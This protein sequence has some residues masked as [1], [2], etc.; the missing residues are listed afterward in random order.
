MLTTG[1][2]ALTG[3]STKAANHFQTLFP[4]TGNRPSL[5]QQYLSK[6]IAP[7]R[8][9]PL[10]EA[11]EIPEDFVVPEFTADGRAIMSHREWERQY[12]LVGTLSLPGGYGSYLHQMGV[13]PG[14]S[15]AASVRFSLG[16]I[17]NAHAGSEVSTPD[18]APAIHVEVIDL[19]DGVPPLDPDVIHYV[20]QAIQLPIIYNRFGGMDSGGM[21][22][23]LRDDKERGTSTAATIPCSMARDAI[24]QQI[25]PLTN[26]TRYFSRI[27]KPGS[28]LTQMGRNCCPRPQKC[29]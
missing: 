25:L 26:R 27:R 1:K 14:G 3:L 6:G 20:V 21:V 16:Q 29:R 24:V 12:R 10:P 17:A 8:K 22:F 23:V 13:R 19:K 5:L 7:S 4:S 2:T 15:S 28:S 9:Y 11:I 18:S